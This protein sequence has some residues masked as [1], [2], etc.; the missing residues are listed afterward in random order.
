MGTEVEHIKV[1]NS[2]DYYDL[3][4]GEK[5][6]TL[7]DLVSYYMKNSLRKK[8]GTLIELK[9]PLNSEEPTAER[10]SHTLCLEY[11]LFCYQMVLQCT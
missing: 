8:N 5:F 4:G 1:Q 6:A 3:Y 7:R 10:Y 9:N 2:G 11:K